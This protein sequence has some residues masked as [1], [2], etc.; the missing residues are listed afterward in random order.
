MSRAMSSLPVPLSPMISTDACEKAA[1]STTLRTMARHRALLPTSTFFTAGESARFSM[2]A[3]RSSRETTS[4]RSRAAS[5]QTRMSRAP[6]REIAQSSARLGRTGPMQMARTV[7]PVAQVRRPS[8][9][10]ASACSNTAAPKPSTA[11]GG[12][13]TSMSA[14]R[15]KAAEASRVPALTHP[16]NRT[17]IDSAMSASCGAFAR[18]FPGSADGLRKPQFVAAWCST[19]NTIH[20]CLPTADHRSMSQHR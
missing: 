2:A 20:A 16:K 9:T 4:R 13:V 7:A 11:S 18:P 6:A 15:S 14:C 10:V 12:R 5:R 8:S 3:H 17:H 19:E 1:T